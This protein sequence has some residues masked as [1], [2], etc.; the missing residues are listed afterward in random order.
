M[1]KIHIEAG[2]D[3][4]SMD[5]YMEGAGIELRDLLLFATI[6]IIKRIIKEDV[7]LEKAVNTYIKNLRRVAKVYEEHSH[8]DLS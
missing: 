8:D 1:A 4:K 6:G 3:N 2:K 5:L 7:P